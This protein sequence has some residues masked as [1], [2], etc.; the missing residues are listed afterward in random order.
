MFSQLQYDESKYLNVPVRNNNTHTEHNIMYPHVFT[1]YKKSYFEENI[2][3][4]PVTNLSPAELVLK[5]FKIPH[6]RQ[7]SHLFL[8]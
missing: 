5:H 1:F 3:E 6:T 7:I 2:S 4:G 8:I